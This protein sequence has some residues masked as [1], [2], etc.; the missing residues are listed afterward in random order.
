M[1]IFK[2]Q[3]EKCLRKQET[4]LKEREFEQKKLFYFETGEASGKLWD[5]ALW[6][7]KPSSASNQTDIL[8][9]LT[10]ALQVHPDIVCS[11]VR[12]CPLHA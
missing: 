3:S 10:S 8:C 2:N 7:W 9:D 12:F 5:S 11:D 6:W 4:E 1:E